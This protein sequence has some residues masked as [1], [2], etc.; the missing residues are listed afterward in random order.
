M[1]ASKTALLRNEILSLLES[2]RLVAGQQLPGAR[3]LAAKLQISFLK[4]QQALETLVKDGILESRGRSGT[5][6]QAGWQ[7]RVLHE[8]VSVFNQRHRLT[9]IDGLYTLLEQQLPDLRF[10]HTFNQ[11]M[12]EIKTT[13]YV[14]AH[15]DEFLDLSD[16]FH[17]LCPDRTDFFEHAFAAFAVDGKQYGIPFI[18]SPRVMFYNPALLQ[19]HG[20]AQPHAGWSWDDFM[21]CVRSL[22]GKLADNEIVNWVQQSYYW[23]NFIVRSGGHILDA[24]SGESESAVLDAG[25]TVLGLERFNELG[26][27]LN[28]VS[29]DY[30]AYVQSFAAG[31]SAFLIAGRQQRNLLKDR[32]GDGWSCVPLPHMSPTSDCSSQATDVICV[33]K[34]CTDLARVKSFLRVMLSSEVQDFIG[35]E[36]YG[37]PIRKS[38]AFKSID[39][40]DPRDAI[41]ATEMMKTVHEPLSHYP[42]VVRIV[43]AGI[44]KLLLEQSDL[45]IGLKQLAL[46]ANEVI[47]IQH[48]SRS[49]KNQPMEK[50]IT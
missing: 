6:V 8:N 49:E 48:F 38:S 5:F 21:H 1:T 13:Q 42:Q 39:L 47:K 4:T 33:R 32:A 34:S 22:K 24:S 35:A 10:T 50:E 12:I 14:Q 43:Y 23:L 29:F 16:I 26:R 3:D 18:F 40:S 15:Y 20:C 7:Q 27:V 30:D 25:A 36:Q 46:T 9:W 2:G 11:S 37:I 31:K 17:E 44:N 41:F 28:N 45:K 19:Q